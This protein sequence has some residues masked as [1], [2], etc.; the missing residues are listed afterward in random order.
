[1]DYIIFQRI[2]NMIKLKL[3]HKPT[4]RINIR[5]YIICCDTYNKVDIRNFDEHVCLRVF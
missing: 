1:M 5:G 4:C 3:W 2:L